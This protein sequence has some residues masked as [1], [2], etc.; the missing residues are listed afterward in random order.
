VGRLQ[1][2]KLIDKGNYLFKGKPGESRGRKVMIATL[3]GSTYID[4]LPG[5]LQAVRIFNC[6][7]VN[8]DA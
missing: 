5:I 6:T 2:E 3:S 1:A 4:E 7:G 8:N